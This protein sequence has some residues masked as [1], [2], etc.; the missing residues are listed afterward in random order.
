MQTEIAILGAGPGGYVAALRAAQLGAQV[1]IIEEDN[2]G[3]VCLNVG[4]IPTKALLRSAEIFRTMQHAKDYGLRMVG[5]V[6]PDWPA[7]LKRKER[8]VKRLVGGV[9]EVE[10]D[11][12]WLAVRARWTADLRAAVLVLQEGPGLG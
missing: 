11:R 12:P 2:L 5:T 1:T 6:E 4:C 3:G 9:G 7:I 8:V 10:A